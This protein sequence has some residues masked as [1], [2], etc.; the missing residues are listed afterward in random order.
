[1]QSLTAQVVMNGRASVNNVEC[2]HSKL[3]RIELNVKQ[4]HP[5][6][7]YKWNTGETTELI[8]DLEPGDYTVKITDAVG[9]DTTLHFTI[10]QLDCEMA[11]E[12][13]ITPNGDGVNDTWSIAYAPFF[14][15]CL[16]VVFN[17]LGQK[18]FEFS[19]KY[20]HDDWWDGKDLLGRPLPTGS[21]FFICYS[22][23]SDKSN[24]RKG[25]VSIIR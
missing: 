24:F 25:T 11:P 7:T 4:T 12:I 22:D 6:Y 23:K 2:Q 16:V 18:V 1:M 5:P 15:N 8:S 13:F 20:E 9:S 17:K 3:G 19:G 14:P 10:V 21:Y